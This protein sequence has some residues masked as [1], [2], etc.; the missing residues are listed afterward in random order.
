MKPNS[1]FSFIV[2][3]VFVGLIAIFVQGVNAAPEANLPC[4]DKLYESV[5]S[6]NSGCVRVTRSSEVG[7]LF[8][9]TG[10]IGKLS[11]AMWLKMTIEGTEMVPIL[12]VLGH[13]TMNDTVVDGDRIQLTWD[14][15]LGQ[16]QLR[17]SAGENE[18]TVTGLGVVTLA[19]NRY[20][21]VLL[22]I[23]AST[24]VVTVSIDSV[25][26]I[27]EEMVSLR[28]SG[29]A[30][31]PLASMGYG[32]TATP[33][34]WSWDAITTLGYVTVFKGKILDRFGAEYMSQFRMPLKGTQSG[35]LVDTETEDPGSP[36]KVADAHT[37]FF[38]KDYNHSGFSFVGASIIGGERTVLESSFMLNVRNSTGNITLK[39]KSWTPEEEENH[40]CG[41]TQSATF[42]Y[43]VSVPVN[44]KNFT[45]K[46]VYGT[47]PPELTS[48][49]LI[50][51]VTGDVLGHYMS[52]LYL[53]T[54]WFH[55]NGTSLDFQLQ[56]G[57]GFASF[58]IAAVNGYDMGNVLADPH[59]SYYEQETSI[60][61]YAG[62]REGDFG[63]LLPFNESCFSS[64]AV[65]EMFDRVWT[66][67]LETGYYV[68]TVRNKNP[69]KYKLCLHPINGP[70]QKRVAA[71]C[72]ANDT[73]S[74]FFCEFF[75]VRTPENAIPL[76][77]GWISNMLHLGESYY[78]S[79]PLIGLD[80]DPFVSTGGESLQEPDFGDSLYLDNKRYLWS[81]LQAEDGRFARNNETSPPYWVQYFAI[82][83]YSPNTQ[84]GVINV[85]YNTTTRVYFDGNIVFEKQ[86]FFP[87][88]DYS[89]VFLM[90]EGWHQ[91]IVKVIYSI[92]GRTVPEMSIRFENAKSLS[93]NYVKGTENTTD[94]ANGN[95]T[96][97]CFEGPNIT[98]SYEDCMEAGC[99]YDALN[100]I[101]CFVSKTSRP[102][103]ADG[104]C[105]P[106]IPIDSDEFEFAQCN[107][108]SCCSNGYCG[109]S[110]ANCTCTTCVD[111][112]F[113]QKP[114]SQYILWGNRAMC[115][116]SRDIHIGVLTKDI[117]ELRCNRDD[118]C[119]AFSIGTPDTNGIADC[120]L[121]YGECSLTVEDPR[122]SE[123]YLRLSDEC[124]MTTPIN[125]NCTEGSG[126]FTLY[127]NDISKESCLYGCYMTAQC[128][129]AVYNTE[130]RTCMFSSTN[131][132][133]TSS[134]QSLLSRFQCSGYNLKPPVPLPAVPPVPN[135]T[136]L[137]CYKD[138]GKEYFASSNYSDYPMNNYVENYFIVFIGDKTACMEHCAGVG[139]LYFAL[140]DGVICTCGVYNNE[141]RRETN[142]NLCNI[143]CDD[144]ENNTHCGGEVSA[145]VYRL[146]PYVGICPHGYAHF[147]NACFKFVADPLSWGE[148][149]RHCHG[150]GATLASIANE[151]RSQFLL[152]LAGGKAAWT[153]GRRA[154][155]TG[156]FPVLTWTDG[157]PV[158][159]TDWL[160]G[161][162]S[163]GG[164]EGNEEG[165]GCVL[166]TTEHPTPYEGSWRT[167]LCT[168]SHGFLCMM[169]PR[170]RNGRLRLHVGSV[171]GTTGQMHCV[172]KS[173]FSQQT[174]ANL[175][176][177]YLLH[178]EGFDGTT[179]HDE[180]DQ[181]NDMEVKGA[182]T[183]NWVNGVKNSRTL[184]FDG[185]FH[186]KAKNVYDFQ[187]PTLTVAVWVNI[188]NSTVANKVVL[189]K[190]YS[191]TKNPTFP[192][193]EWALAYDR[194]GYLCFIITSH[195]VCSKTLTP[196]NEWV[197]VA[198]VYDGSTMNLFLNGN[199]VDDLSIPSS[200]FVHGNET[201]VVVGGENRDPVT[202]ENDFIGSIDDVRIYNAAFSASYIMYLANCEKTDS[203]GN[204]I[205]M[206]NMQ[207][208]ILDFS[209]IGFSSDTD[210]V[211][212]PEPCYSGA[213]VKY[214]K[215]TLFPYSSFQAILFLR[216]GTVNGG[217][218][219]WTLNLCSVSSID[220]NM[221][222]GDL[223]FKIAAVS[224][225]SFMNVSSVIGV[226]TLDKNT[227]YPLKMGLV[228]H[229]LANGQALFLSST[230]QCHSEHVLLVKNVD[231]SGTNGEVEL[232]KAL[233]VPSVFVCW[234]ANETNMGVLT[235]F[236]INSGDTNETAIV[237]GS[238]QITSS[239]IQNGFYES[240][241]SFFR[242]CLTYDD[243]GDNFYV[244]VNM[245]SF[246]D[247]FIPVKGVDV[248]TLLTSTNTLN[249]MYSRASP[250][251]FYF[252]GRVH[253]VPPYRDL[254]G[255]LGGSPI[256]YP[257]A[258]P[259]QRLSTWGSNQVV[260]TRGGCC[261]TQPEDI[262]AWGRAYTL[263]VRPISEEKVWL[264]W[265]HPWVGA[266]G[267]G[268]YF[269]ISLR[270]F[271]GEVQTGRRRF[272]IKV[273]SNPYK[274]ML[275]DTNGIL[276]FMYNE[277]N[278]EEGEVVSIEVMVDE[279]ITPENGKEHKHRIMVGTAIPEPAIPL[280][281]TKPIGHLLR[282]GSL[283][284]GI[285]PSEYTD[286]LDYDWFFG[287]ELKMRPYDGMTS[288]AETGDGE[289][290]TSTWRKVDL[291]TSG[292]FEVNVKGGTLHYFAFAL[293]VTG[294]ELIDI[295]VDFNGPMEMFFDGK[296]VFS[297]SYNNNESQTVLPF[298]WHQVLIKAYSTEDNMR[299]KIRIML[300][301]G[302]SF[303]SLPSLFPP[304]T[305][306][307]KDGEPIST[308]LRLGRENEY[309]YEVFGEDIIG[310]MQTMRPRTGDRTFTGHMW[311]PAH[312]SFGQ[313]KVDGT[314]ST[315]GVYANRYLAFGLYALRAQLI[316]WTVYCHGPV[317][318]WINGDVTFECPENELPGR[319]TFYQ[320]VYI[321]WYQM[322]VKI[323]ASYQNTW[324]FSMTPF[325]TNEM[326]AIA[327]E[328][329]S[330][331]PNDIM[332][333]GSGEVITEML[334]LQSSEGLDGRLSEIP[335]TSDV[336]NPMRTDFDLNQAI[337]TTSRVTVNIYDEKP[338]EFYWNPRV[339]TDGIFGSYTDI[340]A[341]KYNQYYSFAVYSTGVVGDIYIGF[342]D[343]FSLFI[344]D[345]FVHN[346]S[347]GSF[348]VIPFNLTLGWHRL[349]FKLTAKD[350]FQWISDDGSTSWPQAMSNCQ[351]S[352]YSQLCNFD[353]Y[354]PYILKRKSLPDFRAS[355]FAPILS[356]SNYG[357]DDYVQ[358]HS[359]GGNSTSVCERWSETH[360]G[361]GPSWAKSDEVV[362]VRRGYGCCGFFEAP[363]IS[364]RLY[365]DKGELGFSTAVPSN[366]V[367]PPSGTVDDPEST[368][369]VVTL[370]HPDKDVKIF[371]DFSLALDNVTRYT[372]PFMVTEN[373]VVIYW[374]EKGIYRSEY[375]YL[376]IEIPTSAVLRRSTCPV[377]LPCAI[378]V[379]G[380]AI[381]KHMAIVWE[382]YADIKLYDNYSTASEIPRSSRTSGIVTVE[383]HFHMFI[384]VEGLLEGLYAGFHYPF[385][386]IG[387][388]LSSAVRIEPFT[389]SPLQ[390]IGHQ[391]STFKVEGL[392]T[393]D[394]ILFLEQWSKEST[395][396][397]V[398]NCISA[399]INFYRYT[400]LVRP[401]NTARMDLHDFSGDIHCV[402]VCVTGS[403]IGKSRDS[404]LYDPAFVSAVPMDIQVLPPPKPTNDTVWFITPNEPS[405]GEDIY[406]GGYF[407]S[408]SSE[409]YNVLI[410]PIRS[411]NTVR[412]P[413][414]RVK[415]V[416]QTMLVCTISVPVG[417]IGL[418]NTSIYKTGVKVT[419][420]GV[421]N[422]LVCVPPSLVISAAFGECAAKSADCVDGAFLT[423]IGTNFD[424][425]HPTRNIILLFPSLNKS[426]KHTYQHGR[427][428]KEEEIIRKRDMIL[429]NAAAWE[430]TPPGIPTCVT[431][432]VTATTLKC[433]LENTTRVAMRSRYEVGLILRLTRSNTR[434][435]TT[436]ETLLLRGGSQPGWS[437][438]TVPVIPPDAPTSSS[439]NTL[440]IVLCVVIAVILLL[441][442]VA[443]VFMK[444]R[445]RF[446]KKTQADEEMMYMEEQLLQ[447]EQESTASLKR[448]AMNAPIPPLKEAQ[449][450]HHQR[451]QQP[452]KQ[453]KLH[454]H[455]LDNNNNNNNNNALN[456]L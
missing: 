262:P 33:I 255:A 191:K 158:Q 422:V 292:Y 217:V 420:E 117:C 335:Y 407:S 272:K 135:A 345:N 41:T 336:E 113:V 20:R 299:M 194:R 29:L 223:N 285:E 87:R 2:Y 409:D 103:R 156:G 13:H 211:L 452:P 21:S 127:G 71:Q 105:G 213:E 351:S 187:L 219:A 84:N 395:T 355:T 439:H 435:Y 91:V 400:T 128:A 387:H 108:H 352:G 275:S 243:L 290:Y 382:N 317:K 318:I 225:T 70:G 406:F 368:E 416:N 242:S 136:S 210:I 19:S 424:H 6:E 279:N 77:S 183:F 296:I 291:D 353:A 131:C 294:S 239:L 182:T 251:D 159:F 49:T 373:S 377:K 15:A 286:P 43:P 397:A 309:I 188:G 344:D 268:F 307:L 100:P 241:V 269:R 235:P 207:R 383:S 30:F 450:H 231:E 89:S 401:G 430:E 263:E 394:G 111:Y 449:Q 104:L 451:S 240:E 22:T 172:E 204:T 3:F 415:Q 52:P 338:V 245:G 270:N 322:I 45:M 154:V 277:E 163:G 325:E 419:Y 209:G 147:E 236:R 200:D 293:F 79:L 85:R 18:L 385:N 388:H 39:S 205:S 380:T 278:F 228:G 132:T 437:G 372:S 192:L 96:I 412:S 413:T 177:H 130:E 107:L 448:T 427:K 126:S 141:S 346:E 342:D 78:D 247:V 197:H 360:E 234:S 222:E 123:T 432:S 214:T 308:A 434:I 215:V 23:D 59:L 166:T 14:P 246:R 295:E 313:W 233:N 146:E 331:L 316:T 367:D 112:N 260:R 55:Y 253:A 350:D 48:F 190:S 38:Y 83:I 340:I 396:C 137:G 150:D 203:L 357:V 374:A 356:E 157:S 140:T 175:V 423:F 167:A 145:S 68:F 12:D 170:D 144:N 206:Y 254:P 436:N 109:R 363:K 399:F 378:G 185:S 339:S 274:D 82:A 315:V 284:E 273:G 410:E 408:T 67:S 258:S 303:Y 198:G 402:C 324:F 370:S 267:T 116:G 348:A 56:S 366:A 256:G 257:L 300:S 216:D 60:T 76:P 287:E 433:Q 264:D 160:P 375:R 174:S 101:K 337:N 404:L 99:C 281:S 250:D 134:E 418:W 62:V 218:S 124:D 221:I 186:L 164:G 152:S 155:G 54:L 298:G 362:E 276:E 189:S 171:A 94:C 302:G 153:G 97:A 403:S 238:K 327:Y 195:W 392:G 438:T 7:S 28:N 229:N 442:I 244:I 381:G 391:D 169:N 61:L 64:S 151:T 390:L 429:H 10:G 447:A 143:S 386:D 405:D 199:L 361:N 369:Q 428:E 349:I 180:S 364:V 414:C 329:G 426:E 328:L 312:A 102:Y 305:M 40:S 73:T 376:I 320:N 66:T 88:N 46:L 122:A 184:Q 310:N 326:I 389:L 421:L 129:V 93:W 138:P 148:A 248:C 92:F 446:V 252:T 227:I 24:G 74:T 176:G 334:L 425:Y 179:F 226:I 139:T 5:C 119:S 289:S 9:L 58:C 196:Q 393:W 220:S 31:S 371:Y 63:A 11:V 297:T 314:E 444:K 343:A 301:G 266:A 51:R 69:G 178:E 445:F 261:Q 149:R 384:P 441:I 90:K 202:H 8:N 161:E 201:F 42:E 280:D 208:G 53:D 379:T 347:T 359:G 27:R 162:P 25:E 332:P 120:Y 95:K 431:V 453:I 398:P 173:E 44:A 265:E 283:E 142:Q 165:D 80:A 1:F 232:T 133:A 81:P 212:S 323:G 168:A 411:N 65:Y 106:G 16:L 4:P 230:S 354:C 224:I 304:N 341:G 417:T 440:I 35:C 57:G 115:S 319:K 125:G 330:L 114:R 311:Q 32:T 37:F 333:L 98:V 86:T 443:V 26:V 118:N 50:N 456:E 36:L 47:N 249:Y 321:G 72:E 237:D 306:V 271:R 181:G 34:P 75:L 193:Y 454:D 110:Y 288:T 259:R 455:L 282:F 358:I 17:V 121:S 365:Y